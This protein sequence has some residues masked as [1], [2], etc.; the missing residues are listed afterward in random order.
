MNREK[1]A[2]IKEIIQRLAGE[3]ISR[4][5]NRTSLITVTSV[6]PN[7]DMSRMKILV[8]V[9]PE[10]QENASMDFLKRQLSD[11][12]EYVKEHSKIPRVPFFSFDI[13]RGEKSRQKVQ[14]IH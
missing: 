11:F 12:R 2:T 10:N 1:E 8:T 4:E 9:L 14:D 5:S 6:E 7:N 3:F 13:D